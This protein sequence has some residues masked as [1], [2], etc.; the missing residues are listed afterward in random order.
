MSEEKKNI[1]VRAWCFTWPNYTKETEDYLAALVP[2]VAEYL[3]AGREVSPTTG[4]PHLQGF[5][6]FKN[7]RTLGGVTKVLEKRHVEPARDISASIAYCKKD[8]NFFFTG[9]HPRKGN[10]ETFFE[11][12]RLSILELQS[13]LSGRRISRQHV[14]TTNPS[15]DTDSLNSSL[16]MIRQESSGFTEEP[17]LENPATS[18]IDTD[19]T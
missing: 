11:L 15:P 3:I 1:R 19:M 18:S 16:A 17:E 5:I 14:N 2:D 7:P 12:N 10:V 8:G 13:L 4:T 6:Y 9:I